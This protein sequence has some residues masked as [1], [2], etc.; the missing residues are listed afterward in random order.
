[1]LHENVEVV[2]TSRARFSYRQTP[3]D[4]PFFMTR[5]GRFSLQFV[6]K[7]IVDDLNSLKI[8]GHAQL[9]ERPVDEVE[10]VSSGYG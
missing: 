10:P 2:C 3:A 9:Q 8:I 4:K 7:Q 5:C 1:V 6:W